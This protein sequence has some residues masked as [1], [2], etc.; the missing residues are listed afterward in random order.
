MHGCLFQLLVGC[1]VLKFIFFWCVFLLLALSPP[2]QLCIYI[3]P[4]SMNNF[5]GQTVNLNQIA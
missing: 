3:K 4:N 2:H 1:R 5:Y